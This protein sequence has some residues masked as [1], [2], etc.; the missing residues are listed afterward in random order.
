MLPKIQL[1][2]IFQVPKYG[3]KLNKAGLIL[4]VKNIFD[5]DVLST[6]GEGK[7]HG[8]VINELKEKALAHYEE[9]ETEI[10]SDVLR[11]LERNVMLQVVDDKWMNHIDNMD[12]L[13]DGI[14]L[15][16]YGQKDP[17]VQYRMEGFEMFD[18][19]ISD[20]KYDVV[21]LLMHK[22]KKENEKRVSTVKIT[23]EGLEGPK[24][25]NNISS[26]SMPIVNNGPRVGRND[27]CT[28]GSG[29]KYKQC[30][31]KDA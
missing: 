21:K 23:S 24:T 7:A 27:P 2:V 8:A 5:I 6:L 14:G 9:K 16:A 3:N 15:R 12:E 26:K 4:D 11:E 28:C 1:I 30:C 17:V 22:K 19:M 10:G 25:Q 31:G 20:I 18:Q 13:R 29:K